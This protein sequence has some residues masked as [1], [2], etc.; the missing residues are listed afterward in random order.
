VSGSTVLEIIIEALDASGP[1]LDSASGKVE[2]AA[3]K[4]KGAMVAASTAIAA[5][6]GALNL[7]DVV[8]ESMDL[9]SSDTMIAAQLG[10]V[11]ADAEMLGRVAGQVWSTGFTGGLDEVRDGVAAVRRDLGDLNEVDLGNATTQVMALAQMSDESANKIAAAAGKMVKTG[12]AKDWQEALDIITRGLQSNANEAGD[13]LD[14]FQE[15]STEFRQL[16]L[17]GAEALGLMNQALAA[18]A[19]NGDV[20]ADALKEFAIRGQGAVTKSADQ[21]AAAHDKARSAAQA[22]ARAE[23][24]VRTS[25]ASIVSAQ[26]NEKDAQDALTAARRAATIALASMQDQMDSA[27]LDTHGAELAL[28][29]AQERMQQVMADQGSSMLDREEAAQAVAEAQR[30]LTEQQKKVDELAASQAEAAKKG[31]EGSD[32]VVAAQKQVTAAHDATA[33]AVKSHK[34]AQNDAISAAKTYTAAKAAERDTL[35]PLGAAYKRLGIDAQ[36]AQQAIA[37]G[38]PAAT[39]VLQRVMDGLRAVKDPAE[40]STLAVTLFGTKAEDMQAA[41]LA[42]DPKTATKGLEDVAGAT[43]QVTDAMSG[44]PKSRVAAMRDQFDLWKAS[45]ID[46][47]GPIGDVATF[48]GAF[49][50]DI[51]GLVMGLGPLVMMLPM[52]GVGSGEAA[53]GLGGLAASV[54][55]VSWPVLA[56]IA[57]IVLLVGLA[58]LIITNWGPITEFFG[59]LWDGISKG[60]VDFGNGFAQGWN[61][62]W[63]GV[64]KSA[65][66]AWKGV[67]DWG[68]GLVNDLGKQWTEFSDLASGA[69]TAIWKAHVEAFRWIAMTWNATVGGMSWT[70]PGWIPFIGGQTWSVPKIPV[71]KLAT[72]GIVT[73]ATLALIGEAGPEAVVP[74]DRYNGGSDGGGGDRVIVLQVDGRELARVVDRENTRNR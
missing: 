4:W 72:G 24:S 57:A 25:A 39:E 31:V 22:L 1:G 50:G 56:V 15:Y 53:V 49:G 47:K 33:T 61:D 59:G 51:G 11:G 29:R 62:L 64:G 67:S 35:T 40:R 5:A 2:G 27:N 7:A 9:N 26:R 13:L 69:A 23:D 32:Q 43:K 36:W 18:G 20:V 28:A 30:S 58:Y 60:F 63:G 55:A 71:P 54:W 8:A 52:L 17:S 44:E 41:L 65:G 3:G 66:D 6:W 48:I 70:V 34:Q 73:S 12:I 37:Q 68:G 16:G 10:A 38:G 45:L 19:R 46:T 74:L 42:L 14:T 21:I